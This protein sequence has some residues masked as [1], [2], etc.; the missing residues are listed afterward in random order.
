MLKNYF[1]KT[2]TFLSKAW[3]CL[4][5]AIG[6]SC[7]NAQDLNLDIPAQS[8]EKSLLQVAE[9]AGVQM[10]FSS[11]TLESKKSEALSGSQSLK[12][13]LDKLLEN[14]GL[15]YEIDDKRVVVKQQKISLNLQQ[16]NLENAEEEDNDDAEEE[17]KITI[18]GMRVIKRDRA[19]TINPV[20]EYDAEFFERF[21][22]NNLEDM[23]RRVPGVS[24]TDFNQAEV[25]NGSFG[26]GA[27]FSFDDR[28]TTSGVLFRG[29][30]DGAQILVNGSR[31]LGTSVDDQFNLSTF[32]ADIIKKIQVIRGPT[33]EF[34]SR[35]SGLTINVILKDGANIPRDSSSTWRLGY[36]NTN[37]ERDSSNGI[38]ASIA[39]SGYI[40][41]DIGYFISGNFT[42]RGISLLDEF[43]DVDDEQDGDFRQ[44][45]IDAENQK[46]S[47]NGNLD[48]NLT[49]DSNLRIYF[50]YGQEEI[51]NE[52]LVREFEI[53]GGVRTFDNEDTGSS[54][55]EITNYSLNAEYEQ[56]FEDNRLFA[57][58]QF[59]NVE[60]DINRLSTNFWSYITDRHAIFTDLRYDWAVNDSTR[61]KFGWQAKDDVA[62]NDFFRFR[63]DLPSTTESSN[64]NQRNEQRSDF[65]AQYE[66]DLTDAWSWTLG[67]RSESYRFDANGTLSRVLTVSGRG[68]TP[69]VFINFQNTLPDTTDY[70]AEAT[71][72]NSHL[73]W[74]FAEQHELRLSVADNVSLPAAT[75][76]VPPDFVMY[77][78]T[79]AC[80]AFTVV[81]FRA[82]LA[83][84]EL[85]P[86]TT[87]STELGWDWHF[88]DGESAGV[89]GAAIYKK[90][91][92]D[93]F[94]SRTIN[95]NSTDANDP[96]RLIAYNE[97][98]AQA[99]IEL[100]DQQIA[101][102]IAQFGDGDG[103]LG[104]DPT[105]NNEA[106][107]D[108]ISEVIVPVNTGSLDT[109]GF[110]LDFAVPLAMFN[111]PNFTVS[112][113]YTHT[114]N[115]FFLQD[116]EE[117]EQRQHFYNVSIDHEIESVG[118][119]Y[120]FSYNQIDE[121]VVVNPFSTST[122]TQTF[123]RD[124][125]IDF[126]VQKRLSDSL[127]VRLAVNNITEAVS[128]VTTVR[129]TNPTEDDPISR[130]TD[131]SNSPNTL[132]RTVILTV[133]GS[134]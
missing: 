65:F 16:S 105:V 6:F 50:L 70:R 36:T 126:F 63:D 114:R 56:F 100:F 1:V 3:L 67:A 49:D 30:D 27:S 91:T 99:A 2:Q 117:D 37:S 24:F 118:V 115:H 53:T 51:E 13:A 122:S 93:R 107:A 89:L 130:I 102:A 10:I 69:N 18:F 20:L 66:V 101:D 79:F 12:D 116:G 55:S 113:N 22:P 133:R 77:D 104:A 9:I 38:D 42:K 78:T 39:N 31:I 90:R 71:N 125:L 11:E 15:V 84:L 8:T 75:D 64:A 132:S 97:F 4:G 44:F 61:I 34:D 74:K 29:R 109:V 21:E 41:D 106:I 46:I 52:R 7:V 124:P 128:G 127:L 73:R 68:V 54:N 96:G 62:D 81:G 94:V 59:A 72:L 35:G 121:F 28:E 19:N 80:C 82:Q 108:Y 83:N 5:L 86:S 57:A 87:L 112:G 60:T 76:L 92:E 47:L 134:F 88:G 85:R 48:V 123:F 110:E 33:A 58:I 119:T 40:N 120:G 25:P 103:R 111:L 32:P 23:L 45:F 98:G 17:N 131:I 43:L 129:R 95:I 14:T 26:S